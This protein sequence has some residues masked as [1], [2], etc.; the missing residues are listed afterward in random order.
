MKN[1]LITGGAGFI[2]SHLAEYLLEKN[3]NVVI[4]DNLSTGLYENISHLEENKNFKF[5][6]GDIHEIEK[7]E[8]LIKEA[9]FVFHLA[10]A[11][12]VKFIIENPI[13]SITTNVRGTE[14]VLLLSNKFK[15][16]VYIASSSEVYGKNS[17]LPLSEDDDRVL[18]PT[19]I[20]RWSYSCS[21]SI[22]EFLAL[23]YY[24]EK[25]L[26]VIIGRFFNTCGPRQIGEYGM[27]I[28]RFVK[29]A[30]LDLPLFIHGD[31]S[32]VRC[33][34]HVFD[35]VEAMGR[36]FN[37]EK[38]FGQTF[39]IGSS[40]PVTILE[41]AQKI[42][43]K[44]NSKS[45]LEFIPY[46]KVY[47]KNFQDMAKRQPDNRKLKEFTDFDFRYSVD[48]IIDDVVAYFKG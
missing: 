5:N 43:E 25:K 15:K 3:K 14:N 29:Q 6:F 9:D 24:H 16:P 13:K 22:D 35:T 23:A 1:I 39:N 28:P 32:Q 4:F 31:G 8:P 37:D 7:L 44:T 2:G 46:E 20:S 17:N 45:P 21:K 18:G 38:C 40:Y 19:S 27:V 33:F 11:V 26:P 12:G 41:L 36:L 30:L 47:G 48:D 10:A 34:T 42:L